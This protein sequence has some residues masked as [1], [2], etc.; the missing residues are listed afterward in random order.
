MY[1]RSTIHPEDISRWGAV[2]HVPSGLTGGRGF[3]Y[4]NPQRLS[5]ERNR[6]Y[7]FW[8][9][10]DWSADYAT[11]SVDGSWSPARELIVEPGQRPY[12]KVE[13][14]GHDTIGFAFTDGHPRERATSIYYVAYRHGWLRHASGRGI[15]PLARAPI[16]SRQADVVYDGTANGISSWV[17]DVASDHRRRPVIVY[18]TFPSV[19]NHAY[20]YARWNGRRWVS[21]FLAYA[22]P[23]ISPR[24]IELQYSGGMALDHSDPSVVYLSR[25]VGGQFEIERWSTPNG[26]YSWYHRTVVRDGF[27]GLRPVV[28]R[29]PRG[30]IPLL[31]L[32]GHYGS[33]T[34]YRTSIAFLH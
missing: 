8:R 18:A 17:W 2:R 21:H 12:V 23:T 22:G 31:W 9:G 16:L 1:Y 15:T 19:R 33:Y 4:P 34:S 6:T 11:R 3:T 20:W 14:D 27:D 26:G 7:L 32:Q 5:G 25:K 30:G 13:S 10:A 24:T 28:P 29:G